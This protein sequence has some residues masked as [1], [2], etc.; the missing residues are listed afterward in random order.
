MIKNVISTILLLILLFSIFACNEN[1]DVCNTYTVNSVDEL[2]ILLNKLPANSTDKPYTIILN[3]DNL[4]G[5]S[6]IIEKSFN[7][8]INIDLSG[9]ALNS[10]DDYAFKLCANLTSVTIPNSVTSIGNG[11]FS[12]CYTL[13]SITLPDSIT[14]IENEVFEYCFKLESITIPDSV[15]SIGD[16]AF[17]SCISLTSVIIPNK[18]KNIGKGAFGVCTGITNI[19]IPDSVTTIGNVAFQCTSLSNINIPNSVTSIGHEVFDYCEKFFAINV[20]ENNNNFSSTDGVLYNKKKT[21]ILSYPQGK[22]DISF[23][24]PAGVITIG[25]SAFIRCNNLTSVILPNSITSIE[26]YAFQNCDDLTSV[27]FE[28]TIS[29]LNFSFTNTFPSNLRDKFYEDD[30][31]NGTPGTY[32]RNYMGMIWTRQL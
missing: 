11:A 12:Y 7:K 9:S 16:F 15:T 32:T 2:G 3:V 26:D 4:T 13:K 30:A 25:E 28:G 8:Y 21:I 18:I 31:D 1:N 14:S 10:I 20:D 24:I 6:Q 29:S 17:Y 23:S 27:T 19:N 5:I 22:T